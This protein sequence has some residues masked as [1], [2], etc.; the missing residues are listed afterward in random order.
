MKSL[1]NIFKSVLGVVI[2]FLAGGQKQEACHSE[3]V[4]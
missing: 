4:E 1:F 2:W 3:R